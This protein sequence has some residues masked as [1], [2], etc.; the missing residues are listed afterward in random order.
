MANE[1]GGAVCR[2]EAVEGER[3]AV[4]GGWRYG[5]GGGVVSGFCGVG[6]RYGGV[7]VFFVCLLLVHVK[8]VKT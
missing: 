6:W 4:A 7:C 5:G 8:G 3:R 2:D 1:D